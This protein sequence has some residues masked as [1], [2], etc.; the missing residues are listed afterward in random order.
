MEGAVQV[1]D[2][3]SG[4]ELFSRTSTTGIF[5]DVCFSPDG[6]RL[7]LS[8]AAVDQ[9]AIDE[10][11][12]SSRLMV[13]ELDGQRE[14]MNL[15]QDG[16]VSPLAFNPDGNRLAAG[17]NAW[18]RASPE[19][20]LRVWD[21]ATGQPVMTYRKSSA[22]FS[23]IAF[24]PTSTVLAA[25]ARRGNGV[26]VIEVATGKVRWL[27]TGLRHN[28]NHLT[29]SPD[30]SRLAVTGG[31]HGFRDGKSEDGTGH[32]AGGVDAGDGLGVRQSHSLR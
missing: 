24:D 12:V 20:G 26:S 11:I 10:S 19:D 27:L 1:W 13:H 4:K 28:A 29:F 16:Y 2:L 18:C 21:I 25:S 7:A 31:A 15:A 5:E 23:G 14:L 9:P 32:R 17:I 3:Q 8:Q 30:G 6:S 22:S